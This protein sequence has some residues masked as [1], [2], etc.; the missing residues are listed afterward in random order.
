MKRFKLDDHFVLLI[1]LYLIII[2]FLVVVKVNRNKNNDVL[3]SSIDSLS[4]EDSTLP[5]LYKTNTEL[6]MAENTFR[7]YVNSQDST[8]KN[9]FLQHITNSISCLEQIK[10][11]EDSLEISKILSG[12]IQGEKLSDAIVSLKKLADSFLNKRYNSIYNRPIR[13]KEIDS[14]ILNKYIKIQTT[15]TLKAVT[16]KKSLFKRLAGAFANKD[17]PQ[18]KLSKDNN[19]NSTELDSS[20]NSVNSR[21]SSELNDLS[22]QIQQFYQHFLDKELQARKELNNAEKKLAENNI[23]IVENLNTAIEK[24]LKDKLEHKQLIDKTILEKTNAIRDSFRFFS[25]ILSFV[26]LGII[27][28]LFLRIRKEVQV[29]RHKTLQAVS[30]KLSMERQLLQSQMDPHFVFNAL[31]SI[32]NFVLKNDKENASSYLSKFSKLMRQILAHSKSDKILLEDEISTL[33]NY[34][35]IKRLTLQN[36]FDYVIENHDLPNEDI[37]IPPMLIQP[38][39]EN[40]IDHGLRPLTDR[41]GKLVVSFE[42]DENSNCIIC[43][44]DDNG[45]GISHSMKVSEHKS[46]AI[47]ISEERVRKLSPSAHLST[48]RFEIIDKNKIDSTQTGTLVIIRIPIL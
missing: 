28:I 8:Y 4:K 3:L 36:Q 37:F 10:F 13:V 11:S 17:K 34:I 29:Q 31:T 6:S 44:I 48:E 5:L 24:R 20:A 46:F 1:C 40:A 9:R 32:Q 30:Q 7:I 26:I 18:L 43:K 21:S 45:V 12:F 22:L 14:N 38:F 15:D 2:A 39:I 25:W 42:E 41:K 16:E 27:L 33:E 23:A 35:I 19:S 47:Q